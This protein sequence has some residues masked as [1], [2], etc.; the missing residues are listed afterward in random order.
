MEPRRLHSYTTS[1]PSLPPTE[2]IE[3]FEGMREMPGMSRA[4][5][6]RRLDGRNG[7]DEKQAS[8]QI[9]VIRKSSSR[10]TDLYIACPEVVSR[11]EVLPS[12]R[13]CS[14]TSSMVKGCCA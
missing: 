12:L 13:L 8:E 2:G 9:P 10:Q 3:V 7:N 5:G 4:D 1:Q 14:N 6:E 11:I